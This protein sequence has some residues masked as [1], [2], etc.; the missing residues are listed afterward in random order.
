MEVEAEKGISLFQKQNE[1]ISNHILGGKGGGGGGRGANPESEIDVFRSLIKL[2]IALLWG[3]LHG[4]RGQYYYTFI[5]YMSIV[6]L[7]LK[8]EDFDRSHAA[9]QFHD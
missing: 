5:E 4:P 2:E 1:H 8:R 6:T 7:I 3:T 9:L